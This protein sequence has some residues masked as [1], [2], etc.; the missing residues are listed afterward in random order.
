MGMID[1][2]EFNNV[3]D[4]WDSTYGALNT[5][6]YRLENHPYVHSEILNYSIKILNPRDNICKSKV[7]NMSVKYA[8]GELM[9]YM[10]GVNSLHA[11]TP[12]S[13]AWE[14]LTDDGETLNSAYGYRIH[15]MMGWDQLEY[16]EKLL[17]E[18]VWSRQAIVHIKTPDN[19][20]TKDLPCTVYL[21]YFIR[22]GK[23]H[24]ITN[25]RSN[26][27]WLGFPYDVFCF[28][29]YQIIL[30]NRLNLPVGEYYH[31]AGSMHLYKSN[32]SLV[33]E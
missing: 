18:D 33:K 14:K 12:Y 7:R 9:W 6:L 11:I 1:T 29:S 5:Q 26:D 15:S 10:S 16:C 25:M 24:A 3:T 20:P 22:N 28:T 21:Q 17:R 4:A 23:L 19:T 27:I 31:N 13:K 2:Y 8:I 32:V 30:A